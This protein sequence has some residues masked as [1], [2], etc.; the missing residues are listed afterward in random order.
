MNRKTFLSYRLVKP[1]FRAQCA[2]L[3]DVLASGDQRKLNG[4]YIDFLLPSARHYP[5]LPARDQTLLL[6]RSHHHWTVGHFGQA[7]V[8][9]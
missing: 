8:L 5:A 7:F 9:V 3:T 2:R 4:P 1:G 6:N